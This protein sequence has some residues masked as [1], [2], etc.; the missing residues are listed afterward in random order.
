MKFQNKIIMFYAIF[1]SFIIMIFGGVYLNIRIGNHR[2]KVESQ[3][4]TLADVKTQQL[5]GIFGNMEHVTTY[6]LSDREVLQS[7]SVLAASDVGIK[8]MEERDSEYYYNEEVAL[9]RTRLETYYM[10]REFHKIIVFNSRGIVISNNPRQNIRT[11]FTFENY[12]WLSKVKNTRGRNNI[13]GLHQDDWDN[14]HSQEVVSLIREIQGEK[15]G[16]VEVQMTEESFINQLNGEDDLIDYVVLTTSGD[17]ICSTNS[18]V[19]I[20]YLKGK[21]TGKSNSIQQIRNKDGSKAVLMEQNSE[22]QDIVLLIINQTDILGSALSEILPITVLLLLVLLG[23]SFVYIYLASIHL[24]KPIRQLQNFMEN[25]ELNNMQDE[26]TEKIS[27]DE[28]ES[29]YL[30][31]KDVL[32]R[33]EESVVKEKRLSIM[34]LQAQFDLLQA[35]VNPHFLYNVLNVISDRGMSVDDEVVCE[36]CSD[37]SEMLRY[38]TNTKKKYAIIKEEVDY[39]QLY[40]TLLKYRYHDKLNY[41]LNISEDIYHKVLPKIVLQQ[42][43][44]NSILHG[45]RKTSDIIRIQ[46]WGNIIESGWQLKVVDAGSGISVEMKSELYKEIQIIKRKL[47][48]NLENVEMEIGGMGIINTYARLYLLYGEHLSFEILDGEKVGTEIVIKVRKEEEDV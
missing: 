37:L 38:S 36:I 43:V 19:D 27:N 41:Q 22:E 20:E 29:L 39:L 2:T 7:L 44:E 47:S 16:Y 23:A 40:L 11:S 42:L 5:N 3:L 30:S 34:Q 17:L 33:L 1:A 13:I 48:S 45:Y 31:Y 25:T 9:I 46:I 4:K 35:Q 14:I 12:P 6:L 8:T 18:N 10:L 32:Y 21:M 26:I 24:A 15:R 28:I